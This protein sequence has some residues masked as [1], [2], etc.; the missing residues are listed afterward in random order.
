MC[1]PNACSRRRMASPSRW[2]LHHI[3]AVGTG[4]WLSGS[5]QA[6]AVSQFEIG[7]LTC[8]ASAGFDATAE[9]TLICEFRAADGPPEAYSATIKEPDLH[10]GA[11]GRI[12][13]TV[14]SK[15]A[16][17]HSGGLAGDYERTPAG[18]LVGGKEWGIHASAS[19]RRW[20]VREESGSGCK[21]SDRC[22]VELVAT[23]WP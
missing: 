15:R 20:C 4:I 2:C 13:W 1:T 3:L 9:I 22:R 16:P 19:G 14:T 21:S 7:I 5:A 11:E 8:N 18:A 12:V 17:E 10:A 6:L 23:D